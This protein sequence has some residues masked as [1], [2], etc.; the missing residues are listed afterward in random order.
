MGLNRNVCTGM[1]EGLSLV[2]RKRSCFKLQLL[3]YRLDHYIVSTHLMD[4]GDDG[5]LVGVPICLISG[6]VI[7]CIRSSGDNGL[8]GISLGA[9]DKGSHHMPVYIVGI[10][11]GRSELCIFNIVFCH[12]Q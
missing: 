8:D 12:Y 7:I 2:L 9:G 4:K 5:Q 10:D 1:F 11:A 6:G 3:L